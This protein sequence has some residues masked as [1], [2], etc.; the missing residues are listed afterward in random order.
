MVFF[1]GPSLCIFIPETEAV[2]T[3]NSR[4]ETTTIRQIST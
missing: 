3:V 2:E 4:Q 1:Y